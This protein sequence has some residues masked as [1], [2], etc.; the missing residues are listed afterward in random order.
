MQ[1]QTC[2][3][4][5]LNEEALALGGA[6]SCICSKIKE[7]DLQMNTEKPTISGGLN[8]L[9]TTSVKLSR[10][11]INWKDSNS[12]KNQGENQRTMLRK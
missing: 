7:D 1:N 2:F 3:L 4:L 5:N 9:K 12:S 8:A 11:E 6:S 10:G